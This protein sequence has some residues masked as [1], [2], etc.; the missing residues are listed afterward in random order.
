[1]NRRPTGLRPHPQSPRLWVREEGD[2]TTRWTETAGAPPAVYG[3]RWEEWEGRAIRSFEPAR[4]KLSAALARGW[5]GGLPRPGE[6]WLY[7]GAASGTTASHVADLVGPRGAVYAVERSLRPFARLDLLANRWANLL[8]ILADA[9]RPRDYLGLVPPV[10][11]LYADI[12]QPDQEAIVT[13][14]A[15]FFLGDEGLLLLAL[16]GSSM[17]R[18]AAPSEHL[19]RVAGSLSERFALAPPVPLAPFHRAH[20]LIGGTP[21]GAGPRS[22]SLTVRPPRATRARRRR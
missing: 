3:E 2:R 18:G 9:R 5:E 1:M 4:S 14:N 13:E 19:R 6:R 11:G 8:P 15:R 17:G 12:A 20:Y 7:L 16:K 21:R 10:D 22:G